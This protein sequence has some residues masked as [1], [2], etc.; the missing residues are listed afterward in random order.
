[1]RPSLSVVQT[2]PLRR[3]KLAPADSS[4]TKPERAVDQAVDKPL[5][6]DRDFQHG[7][8]EAFGYAV[9]D[10]GRDQRLADADFRRP[11]RPVG[12]EVLDGRRRG[13]GSGSAGRR[14]G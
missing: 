12:E 6:A 1:M 7:A 11:F 14:S 4:P 9:D 2:V 8:A 5:E 13:S 3:R 10:G